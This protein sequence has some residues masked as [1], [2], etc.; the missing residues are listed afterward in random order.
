MCPHLEGGLLAPHW[1]GE[2]VLPHAICS[3]SV[4]HLAAVSIQCHAWPSS[5][6][7]CRSSAGALHGTYMHRSKRYAIA[8]QNS[9]RTRIET[10]RGDD[11]RGSGLER[12]SLPVP[13]ERILSLG[14]SCRNSLCLKPINVRWPPPQHKSAGV[15]LISDWS[16]VLT[17]PMTPI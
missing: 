4:S 16:A 1:K 8:E 2:S 10:R 12:E 9:P 14:A 13:T 11:S 3:N 15:L 6:T 5:L 7:Q 17:A